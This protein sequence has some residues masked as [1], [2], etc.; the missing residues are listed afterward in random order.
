[1]YREAAN[2]YGAALDRL[3]RVY[4]AGLEDRLD[5]LQE[6]HIALWRSFAGF[7]GRCSLRTWVH[8]VAHNAAVSHILRSR[9]RRRLGLLSIEELDESEQASVSDSKMGPLES[10]LFFRHLYAMIQRLNPADRQIITLYLEGMDAASIGE[11]AGISSSYAAT[12]I[13]RIKR[14]LADRFRN[15][16]DHDKR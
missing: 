6:I 7:D 3:A 14:I 2:T 11:I 4:E 5:L 12:K 10:Q 16:G 15:G 1:M 9:K 13:H 8:R